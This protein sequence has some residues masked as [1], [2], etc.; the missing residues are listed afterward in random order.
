MKKALTLLGL[1]PFMALAQSEGGFGG[2]VG[3]I[4]GLIFA[5]VVFYLIRGLILWYFKIEE[6]TRNQATQ[7]EIL[8]AILRKMEEQKTD[9]NEPTI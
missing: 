2:F 4:I 8:K 5:I 6:I 9:T 1:V 3:M 7:N